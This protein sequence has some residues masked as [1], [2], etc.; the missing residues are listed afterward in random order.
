[1][2]CWLVGFLLGVCFAS[3]VWLASFR[4]L[5]LMSFFA[6]AVASLQPLAIAHC[7]KT[8]G[9]DRL[10]VVGF[11]SIHLSVLGQP[12]CHLG[13]TLAAAG[14]TWGSGIGFLPISG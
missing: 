4:T 3:Y 8:L 12:F 5:V 13:A 1:M 7:F 6:F 10:L 9:S 2:D 11:F 14:R